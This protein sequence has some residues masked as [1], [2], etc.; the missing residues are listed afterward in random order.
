[1]LW[2]GIWC[3]EAHDRIAFPGNGPGQ[4]NEKLHRL[5]ETSIA[6]SWSACK[7]VKVER[8][9]DSDHVRIK[10][11]KITVGNE[12]PVMVSFRFYTLTDA[13]THL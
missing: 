5:I 13:P 2:D 10:N 1:M 4:E 8:Q 12:K 7:D 6:I 11:W 3:H 9:P